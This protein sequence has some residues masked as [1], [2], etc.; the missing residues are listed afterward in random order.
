MR[1]LIQ[2]STN[3]FRKFIADSAAVLRDRISYVPRY[4]GAKV[5]IVA[6][7][8]T[9]DEAIERVQEA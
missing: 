8:E 7:G 9:F 3:A 4:L 6:D 5:H 2:D 1:L